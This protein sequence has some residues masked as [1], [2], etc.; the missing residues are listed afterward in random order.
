VTTDAAQVA[1]AGGA[2]DGFIT[3]LNAN[4]TMRRSTYLGGSG[5]DGINAIML[6]PYGSG[7]VVG[8]YTTSTDFP[9]KNPVQNAN[10]GGMDGFIV[11]SAL[12]SITHATYLGGAGSDSVNAI[13][14]D[15]LY[16]FSAAGSTGSTNMPIA[17]YMPGFQGSTLGAFITKAAGTFALAAVAPPVFYLDVWHNTGY[18]GPNVTLGAAT[19]GV[20]ADIPIAGDWNG[21]GSKLLGVFRD[22]QWIVDTNANGVLDVADKTVNF[23][24]AGDRP[25][26]GDWNGT[27]KVKLGLF[28]SGTFILDLSGRL[29]G[30][31]TGLTDAS[32][33]FGLAGDVPVA[34]D[35]TNSGITRVGVFRNGQW[36]IDFSGTRTVSATWNFG[37]AG[38]K[39][40]V[41][42]WGGFGDGIGVYRSGVW[43][44]DYDLSRTISAADMVFSFGGATYLPLV[45]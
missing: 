44:L 7:P 24:Q 39:P 28:R 41:G 27:G 12:T 36:L 10:A 14:V 31:P 23:G 16:N 11:R 25:V 19:Y 18:N 42:N 6:D 9:T 17:G 38:D 3:N 40:V 34:G 2:T 26:V 20:S 22:G 30:V 4:G 1:F 35:W 33:T 37:Q 32:F 43:Y 29:S 21:T 5:D 8:G 15:T 45:W 13:A